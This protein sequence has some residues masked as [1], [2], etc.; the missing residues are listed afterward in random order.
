[1]QASNK[2]NFKNR[3]IG[4]QGIYLVHLKLTDSGVTKSSD[5]IFK[6]EKCWQMLGC[7]I[8]GNDE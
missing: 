1:M 2:S 6:A 8:H 5:C 7:S 4:Y 3:T